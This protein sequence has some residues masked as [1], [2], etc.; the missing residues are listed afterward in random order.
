MFEFNR[1]KANVSLQQTPI[2]SALVLTYSERKIR[3]QRNKYKIKYFLFFILR[4][5]EGVTLLKFKIKHGI[6]RDHTVNIF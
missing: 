2:S 6:D 5:L 3:D 4:G 1:I